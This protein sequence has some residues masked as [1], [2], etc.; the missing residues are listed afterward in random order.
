MCQLESLMGC[1][2]VGFI[3][4]LAIC[5]LTPEIESNPERSVV[6]QLAAAPGR[7]F[8]G[9]KLSNHLKPFHNG[10]INIRYNNI[11]MYFF[12]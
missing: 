7:I 1:R 11:W 10:H 9:S 8:L 2:L 5:K 6:F 4:F 3:T 12:V